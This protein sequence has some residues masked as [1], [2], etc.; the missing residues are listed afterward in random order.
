MT[1]LDYWAECI[2]KAAEDCGATLTPEQLESIAKAVEGSHENYG[3]AFYSPSWA[4][5]VTD[6]ESDGKAKLKKLQAE[7]DAYRAKAETAVKQALGEHHDA[8]V[9]IHDDGEVLRHGGRTE[10]IQ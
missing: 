7:F 5:R 8:N 1:P 6:I 10:R 4:E 3:Q 9:T 2:S